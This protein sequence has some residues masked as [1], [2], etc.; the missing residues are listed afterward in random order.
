[1]AAWHLLILA[2]FCMCGPRESRT[3]SIVA[4]GRRLPPAGRPTSAASATVKQQQ[5]QFIIV[6][7]AALPPPAGQLARRRHHQLISLAPARSPSCKRRRPPPL[8][9]ARW[10]R[11]MGARNLLQL[12]TPAADS[13]ALSHKPIACPTM[14]SDKAADSPASH[15]DRAHPR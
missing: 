14:Q 7:A 1:M 3:N 5:Q 12:D 11:T 13:D 9:P 2:G 4:L 6:A 15:K 8:I 10:A